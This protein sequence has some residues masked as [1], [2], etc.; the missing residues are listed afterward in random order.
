MRLLDLFCGAGGAGMGYHRAG[1]LEIVGVDV[2]PQ[3]NYP[4]TFN[5]ADAMT[6]PLDGFDAIH[7]S[8]PCQGYTT[9]NNRHGSSSPLLIDGMR[10]RLIAAGVP[11]V[12]ENVAGARQSMIRPLELTGEM[13][14]LRVHRPRLF[15]SN[16]LMLAPYRPSRQSDPVAVYGK[17][18]G[19]RLW[20]RANGSEL[21]VANLEDG[22][23]AMGIDWMTWDELREAIPPAYTEY[24]GTQL[25]AAL[26]AERL[27]A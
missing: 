9:M 4:F 13:F 8:P 21:R 27:T 14:A 3:P 12:I 10:E 1:F 20:T 16:V 7:A 15:E 19:R 2:Y 22:S 26:N 17:Q 23:H 25:M 6:F 5:Q 18:D 11:Y 24:I